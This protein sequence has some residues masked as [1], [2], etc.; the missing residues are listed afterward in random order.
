MWKNGLSLHGSHFFTNCLQ[1]Y[2][3]GVLKI[4]VT[5]FSPFANEVR[6]VVAN[7]F[8][9]LSFTEFKIL[10]LIK[11]DDQIQLPYSQLRNELVANKKKD[12]VHHHSKSKLV[13]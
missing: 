13:F 9:D 2:S 7:T 12:D 3:K 10:V 4:K 11:Q 8:Q 5:Q 1:V 6:P